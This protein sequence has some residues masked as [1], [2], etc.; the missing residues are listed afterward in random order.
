MGG[1]AVPNW[2]RLYEVV[3]TLR[4]VLY[5]AERRLAESQQRMQVRELAVVWLSVCLG[6]G[7]IHGRV[8]L[9][10]P[11]KGPAAA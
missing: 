5:A 2:S 8:M 4:D 10:R 9:Q 6:A 7:L 1:F 11:F 3:Q